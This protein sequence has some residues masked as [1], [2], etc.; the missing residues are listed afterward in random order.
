MESK[1][2]RRF[3]HVGIS[4]CV[5]GCIREIREARGLALD[6]LAMKCG[7]PSRTCRGS[8]TTKSHPILKL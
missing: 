6:A 2:E 5:E 7:M 1:N 8:K 3:K 4:S